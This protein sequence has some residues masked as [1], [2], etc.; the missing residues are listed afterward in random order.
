MTGVS[1]GGLQVS[2][3]TLSFPTPST[4]GDSHKGMTSSIP[5]G[6]N[7]D[8]KNIMSGIEIEVQGLVKVI[9]DALQGAG[10]LVLPGN[11]SYAI[12]NPMFNNDGDL[13]CDIK[14]LPSETGGK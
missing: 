6:A 12:T 11:G 9:Q 8:A 2:I 3:D 13:L 4:D 5:D 10:K 1:S 7:N 14:Y